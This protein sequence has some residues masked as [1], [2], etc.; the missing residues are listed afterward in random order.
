MEL[1]GKSVIAI[2]VEAIFV[3]L[4]VALVP[5]A[6]VVS[7]WIVINGM[8][9]VCIA[10]AYSR[11]IIEVLVASE[12]LKTLAELLADLADSNK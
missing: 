12:L 3:M 5:A 1:L 9:G 7:A 8:A 6:D 11:S 10:I 4:A 2:L